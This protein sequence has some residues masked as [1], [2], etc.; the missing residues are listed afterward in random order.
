MRRGSCRGPPLVRVGR[1]PIT[2]AAARR[3]ECRP[4]RLSGAAK[5]RYNDRTAAR[6]QDQRTGG[7]SMIIREFDLRPCTMRKE[8]PAW[9]FALAASPVTEGHVVRIAT[10]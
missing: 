9:R 3:D 1:D 7:G 10:E 8:D 2:A 4:S 5:F 6:E